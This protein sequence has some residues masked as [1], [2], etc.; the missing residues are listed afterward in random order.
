[1]LWVEAIHTCESVRNSMANTG[2]TK[3]PNMVEE[4]DINIK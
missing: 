2:S 4:R 3:S 1:M